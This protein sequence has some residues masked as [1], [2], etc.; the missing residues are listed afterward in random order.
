[1][2]AFGTAPEAFSRKSPCEPIFVP[3]SFWPARPCLRPQPSPK[4]NPEA[5]APD[6]AVSEESVG[7]AGNENA[8][9]RAAAAA[10]VK[11]LSVAKHEAMDASEDRAGCSAV[12]PVGARSPI[13]SG[14]IFVWLTTC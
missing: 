8:A 2:I 5:I 7:N 6:S 4:K 12:F 10:R 3:D 1:M 11:L 14:V 13:S 9:L